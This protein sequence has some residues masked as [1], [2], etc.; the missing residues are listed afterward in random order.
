M[1]VRGLKSITSKEAISYLEDY[2]ITWGSPMKNVT[3]NGSAYASKEFAVFVDKYGIQHTFAAPYHPASN[4][5]A[6]NAV[7]TSK[8]KY[9]LLRKAG[10]SEIESIRLFLF[11]NR[12]TTHATTGYSPAELHMG[13]RIRIKLDLIRPTLKDRVIQAQDRQMRNH[14]MRRRI[15]FG[16]SDLVWAKDYG[17]NKW[18]KTI[19]VEKLGAV[20]YRVKVKDNVIWVRHLDQLKSG[21]WSD[22]NNQQEIPRLQRR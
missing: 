22:F 9:Q 8:R 13:R 16:E 20:T 3:D 2:F 12:A 15:S 18:T 5:A 1:D 4:G 17:Q 10:Y 21:R 19:V 7:K 14:P 6:E 11:Q